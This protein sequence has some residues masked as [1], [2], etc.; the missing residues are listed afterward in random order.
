MRKKK[1][2]KQAVKRILRP[3]L[4]QC[5]VGLMRSKKGKGKKTKRLFSGRMGF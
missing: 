2:Y 5:L 3:E 4:T 1:I